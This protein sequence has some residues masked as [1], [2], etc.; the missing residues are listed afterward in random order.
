MTHMLQFEEQL[1]QAASNKIGIEKGSLKNISTR[2]VFF[3]GKTSFEYAWMH[4]GKTHVASIT[5]PLPQPKNMEG[6]AL[7]IRVLLKRNILTTSRE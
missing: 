1:N 2:R 4:N 5:P 3:G 7:F 6:N